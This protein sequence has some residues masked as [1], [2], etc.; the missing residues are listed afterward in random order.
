MNPIAVR[1]L[2]GEDVCLH[3]IHNDNAARILARLK[4][5]HNSPCVKAGG[6]RVCDK[7]CD[8]G[9]CMDKEIAYA[10][11]HVGKAQQNC[12]CGEYK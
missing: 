4:A 7:N 12:T 3:E 10:L 8:H 11:E 5:F 2:E 6:T 9:K 1:I